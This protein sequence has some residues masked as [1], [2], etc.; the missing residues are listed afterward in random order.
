MTRSQTTTAP[1]GMLLLFI[2]MAAALTGVSVP[3]SAAFFQLSENNVSALGNANAGAT[4]AAEDA[5]TVWY[6][7][8]GMTRLS[9]QQVSVAGHFIQPSTE[10]N[11]TSANLSPLLGGGS[12][13]GGNGGDAGESAFVPNLYYAQQL[14]DRLFL[15]VGINAPFGLATDYDDDWVGRYHA[16]RSEIVTININPAIA[17]KID[18][19]FSI[20]GGI[21]YQKLDAELTQAV[22]Y[23][24]IC[25]LAAV[26]ACAAPGANDGSARIEADDDAWGFNLGALWQLGDTRVGAHYRSKM[27]Y[28]LE[29]S[30][31]ATAPSAT[32]GAVGASAPFSIV[33]SGVRADVTLP[34]T[35]SVSLNQKLTPAWT[36][37]ADVTRTFWGDLK[38]LRIDFDSNQSDSVVTLNLD[39]VNRYSVGASFTPGGSWTYRFGVALDETPT[40]NATDRT[41][42][43]PDED[44]LWLALGAGYKRSDALSFDFAYVY[45]KID[46]AEINKQAGTNPAGENFLR[47]SL[48]GTYEANVHILSAQANWKF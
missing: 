45:V 26:G 28:E 35:F 5:S 3:A 30:F 20:G 39:D 19:R 9:G 32:A 15:G 29:G 11:K 43:L 6:N 7:P 41:P 21:N 33:D 2:A 13:S 48:V 42:R 14:S 22:D 47:G 4:A 12:I 31:D 34:A 40:P 23:G 10:F 8:A 25:A 18:D 27:E 36:L 38:E 44:R 16:N 37:V 24:S 17:F 1:A 46:D